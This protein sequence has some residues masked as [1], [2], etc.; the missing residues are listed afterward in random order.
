MNPNI[1]MNFSP[2]GTHLLANEE[3]FRGYVYDDKT[4]KPWK[5]NGNKGKPTIGFGH[6][7]PQDKNGKLL[8]DFSKGITREEGE[9]LFQRDLKRY[10]D[11]IRIFATQPL[12]QNQFDAC[13][14]LCYN[15]GVQAF[16][17]S[18]VC[19]FI[20]A[21]SYGAAANAFLMWKFD[22]HHDPV[23]LPRRNRERTLF[24]TP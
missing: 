20:N 18:S 4:G 13:V 7:I 21:K 10:V 23:L 9:R 17:G 14:S 3:S 2:H 24:L 16:K 12:T 1:A 6:L 15:I 11:A 19:R 8:E 22:D 5:I